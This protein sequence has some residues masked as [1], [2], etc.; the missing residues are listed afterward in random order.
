FIAYGGWYR[1]MAANGQTEL[2]RYTAV[3]PVAGDKVTLRVQGSTITGLVNDAQV[4]QVTDTLY[5]AAG[6][7]GID[8]LFQGWTLDSFTATDL[9]GGT[10]T[11]SS[12]TTTSSTSTSP[13][14]PPPPSPDPFANASLDFNTAAELGPLGGDGASIGEFVNQMAGKVV[15]VGPGSA[16]ACDAVCQYAGV[17]TRGLGSA[18][19]AAVV[20]EAGALTLATGGV[21]IPALAAGGLV[22]GIAA[23]GYYAVKLAD[24]IFS[25]GQDTSGGGCAGDPS[26]TGA[27]ST[28]SCG[29]LDNH[30]YGHPHHLVT[31]TYPDGLSGC[32]PG[33]SLTANAQACFYGDAGQATEWLAASH[34]YGTFALPSLD[35]HPRADPPN[36]EPWVKVPSPGPDGVAYEGPG[37]APCWY[38]P[39]QGPFPSV[40]STAPHSGTFLGDRSSSTP[41]TGGA[42]L[43]ELQTHPNRYPHLIHILHQAHGLANP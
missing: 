2:A 14:P 38:M 23:G 1:I 19:A 28:V 42:A 43:Q 3:P 13:P 8:G 22:I 16:E 41:V 7:A 9:G 35:C 27:T 34:F 17:V 29:N 24:Q 5:G 26:P 20:D 39:G 4:L 6:Q 21:D 40:D 12:S 30:D 31:L 10:S 32:G 25:F 36:N 11:S 15:G 18:D 33:G 37:G